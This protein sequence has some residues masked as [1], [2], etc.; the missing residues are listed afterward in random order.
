MKIKTILA[1][2]NQEVMTKV[3]RD[4]MWL[5]QERDT[6]LRRDIYVIDIF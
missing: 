3:G 2:W 6:F 1:N 4:Q 5:R